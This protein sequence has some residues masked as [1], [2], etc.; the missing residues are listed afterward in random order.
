MTCNCLSM[1]GERRGHFR[2][3]QSDGCQAGRDDAVSP[4]K[5]HAGVVLRS[6][7]RELIE[8]HPGTRIVGQV[9][10]FAWIVGRRL[11]HRE[12]SGALTEIGGILRAGDVCD[13]LECV[14]FSLFGELTWNSQSGPAGR[15]GGR[16]TRAGGQRRHTEV[17]SR[18]CGD[19][20]E[21]T[22]RRHSGGQDAGGELVGDVVGYRGVTLNVRGVAQKV[23]RRQRRRI[24][25]LR[26]STGRSRRR[27]TPSSDLRRSRK[28]LRHW[29]SRVPSSPRRQRVA[30]AD[31]TRSNSCQEVGSAV[32][33]AGPFPHDFVVV[34]QRRRAR[35]GQRIMVAVELVIT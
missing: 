10:L 7:V 19:T 33:Q 12:I 1:L 25:E 27:R 9:L 21:G 18:R 13:E 23:A 31:P 4:G 22:R 6:G 16:S 5:E 29:P 2:S 15:A 34:E 8:R 26:A 17:E 11:A 28:S 3:L 20:D 24:G 30:A 32:R 14:K 35:I